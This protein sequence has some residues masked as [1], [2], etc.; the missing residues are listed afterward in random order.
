MGAEEVGAR[1]LE[2]E[3]EEEEYDEAIRGDAKET[4]NA[5][6][7]PSH[8]RP[9]SASPPESSARV[10]MGHFLHPQIT[11]EPLIGSPKDNH[12]RNTVIL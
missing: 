2:T 11:T 4:L 10:L 1:Q 8:T 12:T 5:R 7:A 9:H 3:E 6:L